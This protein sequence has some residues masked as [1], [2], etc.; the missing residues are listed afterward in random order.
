[1]CVEITATIITF[2]E[3]DRIGEAIAS[4]SC[5][6]EIVVVD[7]GSTDRT[8]E[9]AAAR[10]ARVIQRAW[11]GYSKQKNFAAEQAR[12]DWILSI[13]ADERVSIEL[14][15]EIVHWKTE[16]PRASAYST[17]RQCYEA[18][19]RSAAHLYQIMFP[20]RGIPRW[21]AWIGHR[22]HGGSLCFQKGVPY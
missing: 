9:I 10:G 22:L 11:Q 20:S 16:V 21:M 13:D 1:M 2:N 5:C 7:S 8:R 14:A 18:C 4:L 15:D 6:D 3:E 19:A 17:P 12:H